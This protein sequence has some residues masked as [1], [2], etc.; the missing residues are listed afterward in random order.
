[1]SSV[2][3]PPLHGKGSK[4][5]AQLTVSDERFLKVPRDGSNYSSG[6][7]TRLYNISFELPMLLKYDAA[8]LGNRF[9]TF[10]RN[11]VPRGSRKF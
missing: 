10:R 5:I 7:G 8:S 11:V 4:C 6:T 2:T 3:V 9:P 1:M